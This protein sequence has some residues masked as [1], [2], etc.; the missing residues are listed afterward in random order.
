MKAV[1]FFEFGYSAAP[2]PILDYSQG[3]GPT[4][5]MLLTVYFVIHGFR[6]SV[7][8]LKMRGCY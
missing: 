1:A 5:S 6:D 7:P 2:R 3:G 4:P 8:V